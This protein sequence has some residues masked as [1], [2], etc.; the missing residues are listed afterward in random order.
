MHLSPLIVT[1]LLA[2]ITCALLHVLALRLFPHWNL[3]DFPERY[4]LKRARLPYPSGVIAVL[5]FLLFFVGV[6]QIGR[7]EFGL[8][9]GI[10]LLGITCVIDD[11]KPLSPRIRLSCQTLVAVLLFATGTQIYTLTNPLSTIMQEPFFKLDAWRIAM[12]LLGNVP[13]LSAVFTIVWLLLTINALNWFD[14]IPGQVSLLSTIGFLTIGLLSISSR[15]GQEHLALLSFLLAAIAA[16]SFLF[17]VPPPRV[18]LGDSGAMFFGLMLGTLT[19]YAGGK[20][21]TA[22]LVLGV[23]LIDSFFV[24]VRRV[25]SGRSPLQGSNDHLHHRL[26]ARGWSPLHVI[27]LTA[28]VGLLFGGTALFLST[29]QKFIAAIILFLLMLGL[30]VYSRPPNSQKTSTDYS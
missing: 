25:T 13:I 24:I 8:L 27:V 12:P 9:A 19:I 23:P 6:S 10:I 22:F 11:R 3:L 18:V 1:P 28:S 5:T 26:L 17:D 16:T 30:T 2:G 20:V 21:A 15:V 4:G 14:G 29:F 7:Q